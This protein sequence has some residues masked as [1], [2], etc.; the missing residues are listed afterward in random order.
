[1]NL[2]YQSAR[3][4]DIDSAQ[5]NFSQADLNYIAANYIHL[6]HEQQIT[7]SGGIS[8]LWLGTR[9]SADFL[10]AQGCARMKL[11]PTTTP[12]RTARICRTTPRSIWF[13]PR[14]SPRQRGP[15]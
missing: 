12:F 3:G 15:H 8:Y 6:D 4:K 7:A 13:E 9:Y 5:F 10:L 2:A 1:V 11:F 14:L